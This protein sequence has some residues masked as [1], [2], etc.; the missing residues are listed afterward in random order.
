MELILS[1]VFYVPGQRYAYDEVIELNGREIGKWTRKTIEQCK[2]ENPE[3]VC[4]EREE[5]TRKIVELAML[6]PQEITQDAFIEMRNMLPPCAWERKAGYESFHV[7][8]F[9]VMDITGIYVRIGQ[10]YFRMKDSYRLSHAERVEKVKQAF[11]DIEK[12]GPA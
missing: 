6:A 7:A 3:L 12:T 5:C 2:V 8:E 10:R 9:D 1:K 4:I 11:P